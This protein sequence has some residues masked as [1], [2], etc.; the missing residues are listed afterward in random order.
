MRMSD[1]RDGEWFFNRAK[2]STGYNSTPLRDECLEIIKR[3]HDPKKKY[4]FSHIL[5]EKYDKNDESIKKRLNCYLSVSVRATTPGSSVLAEP[6]I[7][8]A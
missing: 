2:T 3:Y 8:Q 6:L 5:S 7:K 1:I 4:I